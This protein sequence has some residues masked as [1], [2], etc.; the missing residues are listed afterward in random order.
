M[1]TCIDRPV[2]KLSTYGKDNK[3]KRIIGF[4]TLS[5]YREK[6]AAVS[7]VCAWV[8]PSSFP[9][10]NV[11]LL[12][13]FLFAPIPLLLLLCYAPLILPPKRGAVQTCTPTRSPPR[14]TA[15]YTDYFTP[16]FEISVSLFLSGAV[17]ISSKVVDFSLWVFRSL[18]FLNIFVIL[19]DVTHS[20]R[21]HFYH[22]L[23]DLHSQ[24][25]TVAFATSVPIWKFEFDLEISIVIE[26][27]IF[28]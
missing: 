11:F 3:D 24:I 14:L 20:I 1:L 18:I 27:Q 4:G 22:I 13:R 5:I 2:N 21:V 26:F 17:N 8:P 19:P 25:P 10:G 16:A 6:N 28:V 23:G 9:F 15:P 12:P 7:S